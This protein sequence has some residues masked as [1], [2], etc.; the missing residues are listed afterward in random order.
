MSTGSPT[1]LLLC[2]FKNC[3]FYQGVFNTTVRPFDKL[4]R[5]FNT[6]VRRGGTVPI[7]C[8]RERTLVK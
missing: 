6:N 7:S 1:M 3:M 5:M 8:K 2:A 4:T